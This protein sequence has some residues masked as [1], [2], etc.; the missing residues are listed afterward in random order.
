MEMK[1]LSY[2]PLA[3]P[4]FVGI[5]NDSEMDIQ[6]DRRAKRDP[7]LK[8]RKALSWTFVKPDPLG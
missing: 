4:F 2:I 6:D 8:P 7:E 5:F 3:G 1:L